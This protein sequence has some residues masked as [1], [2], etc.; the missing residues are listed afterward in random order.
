MVHG[1]DKEDA[2]S[3][4][5]RLLRY[6]KD[7]VCHYKSWESDSDVKLLLAA[8]EK[9]MPEQTYSPATKR[10]RTVESGDDEESPEIKKLWPDAVGVGGSS[11]DEAADSVP[12]KK[13]RK[14]ER[15]RK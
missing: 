3:V 12:L 11:A 5:E 1:T 7:K 2:K 8:I 10:L 14:I 6:L 9:L 13:M 4:K 15:E